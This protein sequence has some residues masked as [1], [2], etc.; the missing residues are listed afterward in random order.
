MKLALI[1]FGGLGSIVAEHLRREREIDFVG[2][3]A[4][5]HQH[6][7]V[8]ALLGDV[9]VIESA[10][11]LLGLGPDLVVECASH[12][13][14]RQYADPV[15][16]SGIDLIAVSVGVLAHAPYRERVL[17]AAARSGAVLEIPAG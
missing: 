1:G 14:F 3:A 17:G 12:E 15:L 4:R 2:I 16:A 10:K 6:E 13:A 8:R 5:N 11:A 9:P 7:R